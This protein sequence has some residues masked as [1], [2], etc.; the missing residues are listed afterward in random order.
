LPFPAEYH[1]VP[2][3][4]RSITES[5]GAKAA[6]RRSAQAASGTVVWQFLFFDAELSQYRPVFFASWDVE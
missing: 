6:M 2:G 5:S 4:L 1:R 3:P